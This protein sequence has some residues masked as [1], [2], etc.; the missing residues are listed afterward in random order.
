MPPV[1]IKKRDNSIEFFDVK[2]VEEAIMKGMK[3]VS[4]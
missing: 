2:K 1:Q 3:S 4:Q